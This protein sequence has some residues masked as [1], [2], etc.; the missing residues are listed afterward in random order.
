MS[1]AQDLVAEAFFKG[2][3]FAQKLMEQ[4]KSAEEMLSVLADLRA[5]TSPDSV[6]SMTD[7][8]KDLISKAD[9]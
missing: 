7:E 9:H 2:V 4:A 1:D 8:V 3:S 6:R 5:V